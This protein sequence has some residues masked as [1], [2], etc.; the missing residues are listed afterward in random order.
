MIYLQ[1]MKMYIKN[2]MEQWSKKNWDASIW[3]M[4]REVAWLIDIIPCYWL[5]VIPVLI[6]YYNLNMLIML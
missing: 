4:K 3:D 2:N 5:M 1:F 6:T